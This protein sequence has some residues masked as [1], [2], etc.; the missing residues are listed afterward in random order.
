[1]LCKKDSR[2]ATAMQSKILRK[3]VAHSSGI[4]EGSARFSRLQMAPWKV[5]NTCSL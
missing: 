4:V 1:M 5:R 3:S 2:I